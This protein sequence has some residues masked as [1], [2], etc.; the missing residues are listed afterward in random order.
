MKRILSHNEHV[1]Y[2][3]RKRIELFNEYNLEVQKYVDYFTSLSVPNF[4][5]DKHRRTKLN[6]DN[7]YEKSFYDEVIASLSAQNSER[8]HEYLRVCITIF[9]DKVNTNLIVSLNSYQSIDNHQ[10]KGRMLVKL[11]TNFGEYDKSPSLLDLLIESK[12]L[13]YKPILKAG[14]NS[15][16]WYSGKGKDPN[17]FGNIL[18]DDM[19]NENAIEVLD[20]AWC[21]LLPYFLSLSNREVIKEWWEKMSKS[22]NVYRVAEEIKKC[23]KY[24]IISSIIDNNDLDSASGMGSMGFSD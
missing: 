24:D 8:E 17:V 5:E 23:G 16:T 13:G 7:K 1:T 21:Y 11:L 6:T 4:I 18:T 20:P 2:K 22:K 15:N 19:F 3:E 9:N 12:K 10:Q 14:E